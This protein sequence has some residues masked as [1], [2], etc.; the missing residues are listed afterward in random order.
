[1][2]PLCRHSS[3]RRF[4]NLQQ[5]WPSLPRSTPQEL[6]FDH[7][8]YVPM[9]RPFQTVKRSQTVQLV[10]STRRAPAANRSYCHRTDST[11]AATTTGCSYG[12]IDEQRMQFVRGIAR[13][14]EH[15]L[16]KEV[17]EA[18]GIVL[19]NEKPGAGNP[20]LK[21][22]LLVGVPASWGCR[23]PFAIMQK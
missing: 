16:L 4:E 19:G 7:V 18:V 20:Q 2:P 8:S 5:Q 1:M 14:F 11:T 6:T 13:R 3:K 17:R 23:M 21:D 9:Q 15:E 22:C 10:I 12:S